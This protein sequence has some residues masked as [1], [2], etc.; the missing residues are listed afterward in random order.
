MAY[1][2]G[3]FT[4][5]DKILPGMYVNLKGEAQSGSDMGS[6][7]KAAVALNLDWGND[8]N[9]IIRV[10]A[11]DFFTDGRKLFGYNYSDDEMLILRQIFMGASEVYVYRLNSSGGVK[12]SASNFANAKYI[13][14][15]GNKISIVVSA[16]VDEGS[17]FDVVT[18]F[19]NMTVDRQMGV[20][21]D[22]LK[23][24]DYVSFLKGGEFSL[25]EGTKVLTGGSNGTAGGVTNH[26]DFLSKLEAYEV[27]AVGYVYDDSS[28]ASIYASWAKTQRDVYGNSIQAVLYNQPADHVAVIN[29]D[30]S[31]ALVPWVLGKE[32]GCA[33]N[34]SLQNVKYDG[35][36][37]PTKSYTQSELE[38]AIQDGKFV[39]HRV[40][41]VFKV[42]ADINSLVNPNA[43]QNEEFKLNQVIRVID[44]LNLDACDIWTEDFIGKVPN[45]DN[46][47][48]LFWSRII[49][50]LNDYLAAGAI[51][52]YD[53]N[54]VTIAAG[55]QRGSVVMQIP[56]QVATMLEKAYV[57]IVVQ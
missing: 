6:R 47:R 15:R 23:D 36:V 7:G 8:T 29:V 38:K 55:A 50:L 13:G 57:T 17:K 41:D 37:K 19:D 2:K 53:K 44:Q 26:N 48:N 18:L 3:P 46:G 56:V 34:A 33:L 39:L 21:A 4:I 16:N 54:M 40:G 20:T 10:T 9:E 12:A 49:T 51:E 42:L 1:G 27:N 5:Q 43:D 32:A 28:T 14:T 11:N 52:E 35:E 24:N 30:D 45:T 25:S 22:T 31:V